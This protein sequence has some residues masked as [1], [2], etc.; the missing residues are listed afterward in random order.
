[1]NNIVYF[2]SPHFNHGGQKQ[3]KV[4]KIEV[5]VLKRKSEN[6]Q[7]TEQIRNFY[8]VFHGARKPEKNDD[9][10]MFARRS[11]MEKKC[12]QI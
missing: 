2:L 1:M 6:M 12:R 11:K 9:K 10:F 7:K 3:K 8:Y 4:I 5:W